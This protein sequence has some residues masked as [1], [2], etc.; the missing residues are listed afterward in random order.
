MQTKE[1][2]RELRTRKGLTQDE[3]AE[4]VFVTRQ[5]V[6]RWE[7]GETTPNVETLKLLSKLFDVSI[8][9]LLGSPRHLICQCCGMPLDD[10]SISKEPDGTFNEEYCKWCYTDGAFVYTKL[11]ELT[12]FMVGMMASNGMKPEQART[13]CE[14]MLPKLGHW[15][16]T[17]DPEK[18]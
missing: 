11:E 15:C 12:D 8:N 4:R 10:A 6:S 7:S 2:L 5:A 1:I 3:L 17:S 16:K 13:L 14:S 9:T 18:L